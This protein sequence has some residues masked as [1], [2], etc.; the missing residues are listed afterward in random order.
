MSA[1]VDYEKAYIFMDNTDP[2][3]SSSILHGINFRFAG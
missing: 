1:D 3:L 2:K